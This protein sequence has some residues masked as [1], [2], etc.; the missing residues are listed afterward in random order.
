MCVHVVYMCVMCAC[1]CVN[2]LTYVH[3]S[4]IQCTN[5]H[6]RLCL[7]TNIH[8]QFVVHLVQNLQNKPIRSHVRNSLSTRSNKL[9]QS[10]YS[11]GR[12]GGALFDQ[13]GSVSSSGSAVTGCNKEK[14]DRSLRLLR[15]VAFASHT[16]WFMV[17]TTAGRSHLLL[18]L[19]SVYSIVV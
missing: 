18:V 19:D 10:D 5:I 15:I 14:Q 3:V 11:V 16:Y 9:A 13:Q 8:T 12:W 17:R 7:L 2:S 1:V 4:Y 6:M